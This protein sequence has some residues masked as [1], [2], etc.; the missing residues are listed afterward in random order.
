MRNP[1]GFGSVIKLGGNRRK[2]YAVRI[3]VGYTDEGKQIY[4]YLSY[5]TNRNEALIALAQY[6]DD[7][8]DPNA[9]S[10]TFSDMYTAWSNKAF[11]EMSQNTQ[12]A[13]LSAYNKCESIHNKIFKDLRKVHLEAV[14]DETERPNMKVQ[15]KYLFSKLYRYAMENEIVAKDYSKFIVVKE[16]DVQK[17]YHIFSRN[18]IKLLWDN[19]GTHAYSDVPLILLYTGMRIGELLA[20]DKENV[21]LNDRYMVGGLKTEAGINRIIPIHKDIMPLIQKRMD[22]PNSKVLIPNKKNMRTTYSTFRRRQWNVYMEKL[23]MDY[24]PHVARHTFIS[25]M[26]Q[27]GINPV[28]IRRIVGHANK[29]ITEVYT[30]KTIDDLIEAIDK[31]K[32]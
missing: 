18:E 29:N 19:V 12:W 16:P 13:Y 14:I 28:T 20:M 5:H 31:L 10:I 17:D 30:H 2:P 22:Y 4:K 15:V 11:Q 3:T 23:G 1:N 8:F 21:H 27:L 25:R 7:P 6:N 24:T 26:D 9:K 32:Y